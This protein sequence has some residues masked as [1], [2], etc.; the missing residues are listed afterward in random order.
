MYYILLRTALIQGIQMKCQNWK[1]LF[2]KWKLVQLRICTRPLK[3]NLSIKLVSRHYF[4]STATYILFLQLLVAGWIVGDQFSRRT[5]DTD[6]IHQIFLILLQFY[7]LKYL[8]SF[9]VYLIFNLMYFVYYQ[10]VNF[11]IYG[12]DTETLMAHY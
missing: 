9:F 12:S 1:L 3:H 2:T 4:Q 6:N 11:R 10:L 5:V 8:I 7:H